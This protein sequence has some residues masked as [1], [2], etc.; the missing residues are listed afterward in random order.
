MKHKL[1]YLSL[2]FL[3]LLG[4]C[5]DEWDKHYLL[6]G[7]EG[8]DN[9]T[10]TIWEVISENP[11]YSAFVAQAKNS[12][13]DS[14]L[15]KEQQMTLWLPDNESMVMLEGMSAEKQ[16]AVLQNHINYV[17]LKAN[18][19]TDGQ[20]VKTLAGK[21]IYLAGTMG[22]WTIDGQ[23]LTPDVAL[24]SNGVIHTIQ[25]LM[26]PR[27][28]IFEYVASLG[29]EYSIVRDTILDSCIKTFRPD[30]SFPLDVDEV[31]NTIYDSVFVYESKLL[32][33]G[34]IREENGE[35]TMFLPDNGKIKAVYEE[36]KS[37]YPSVNG[38]DSVLI[39]NWIFQALIYKGKIDDYTAKKSIQS[40]FGKEW[41]TDI[42][43][44]NTADRKEFTNGYVYPIEYFRIPHF[45]FLKKVET[46]PIYYKELK[47]Q[48][49]DLIDTYFYITTN[50]PE[51]TEPNWDA[52][53]R[54][55][56]FFAVFDDKVK[57]D[58]TFGFEWTSID[59]DRFGNVM[60]VPV[61]PGRYKM[62]Y[63]TRAYGCGNVRITVNGILP[64]TAS[65]EEI[66]Y[67]NASNSKYERK[68]GEIGYIT[69]PETA[70]VNPVR[71]KIEAGKPISDSFSK[72]VVVH[73][74]VF[75]PDGDNY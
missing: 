48:Q 6:D 28:N 68:A 25:G 16:K 59:K 38:K 10:A 21:N 67:F 43:R 30:L 75:E 39:N 46:Y 72:R 22:T 34:D 24:C 73:Y 14:I 1:I 35:F 49:P 11:D 18:R 47:E 4:A 3:F 71:I 19:F 55:E 7:N 31:G 20:Q 51:R 45:S 53:K 63:A 13:V 64:T 2:L 62:S 70:G 5:Q 50:Q 9:A 54:K 12:G 29:D 42:Q 32:A 61:V 57:D 17:A 60:A 23:Q 36:V 27:Q 44:V 37:Y 69:I 41:R 58:E 74:I 26:I 40:T 15:R 33:P 52:D 8:D 65:G 66:P 56:R